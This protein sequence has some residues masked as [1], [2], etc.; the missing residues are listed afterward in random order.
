MTLL[1]SLR[2]VLSSSALVALCAVPLH[3]PPASDVTVLPGAGVS[4]AQVLIGQH[5]CWTGPAPADV[6]FPGHVVATRPDGRTVYSARLVG[7][8]LDHV[9][10]GAHPDLVV[11]AFCK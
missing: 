3:D 10:K 6:V 8:A 7:P 1:R 11:H 5:D 9:F 2:F 4:P